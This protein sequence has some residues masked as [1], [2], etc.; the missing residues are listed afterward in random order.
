MSNTRKIIL[1]V[2][3]LA[4]LIAALFFFGIPSSPTE[5]HTYKTLD[6][7]KKEETTGARPDVSLED[8]IANLEDQ[9]LSVEV[10]PVEEGDGN[11]EFPPYT[12]HDPEEVRPD[13]DVVANMSE[14]ERE[15]LYAD[16]KTYGRGAKDA[17]ETFINW[18]QVGILKK[19][20]GDYEGA[21]DA[22]E[23]ALRVEPQKPVL[24][25]NL[26]DLYWH[27]LKEYPLAEKRFKELI[28]SNHDD[29]MV[30][31]SLSDLYRYAYTEKKDQADDIL[32]EGLE[33]FPDKTTLMAALA[34]VYEAEG[35]IGKAIEWLKKIL[36]IDPKNASVKDEIEELKTAQ[37]E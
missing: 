12:G 28:A 29:F 5:E 34:D 15:Q 37:Q 24:L 22:W 14:E 21:R 11:K 20:I 16:I 26:G 18:L 19:T 6:S 31:R 36:A 33:K 17:P 32:L 7:E 10:E 9:G 30:Y 27:Y 4:L 2:I 3:I 13:P 35:E 8:I 25:K 1:A 23:Y